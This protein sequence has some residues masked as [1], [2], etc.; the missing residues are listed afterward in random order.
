MK[1]SIV[2]CTYNYGHFLGDALKT[3]NAQSMSEFEI[4]VVDDGSTDNTE[5]IVRA[6]SAIRPNLVYHRKSH[7]GLPDSRN[8]GVQ[9]ASGSHIGFL[10]ADDLWSPLYMEEMKKTFMKNR[11]AELVCSDGIRML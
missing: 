3:L 1:F 7:T 2:V 10:D 6:A 4:V 8:Y 5:E 9:A 11:G